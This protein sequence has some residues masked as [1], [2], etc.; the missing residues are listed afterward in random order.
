MKRRKG[1][2]PLAP[3]LSFRGRVNGT[4]FACQYRRRPRPQSKARTKPHT[5]AGRAGSAGGSA[6][7]RAGWRASCL[8]KVTM[9][10]VSLPPCL[11]LSL[12][13]HLSLVDNRARAGWRMQNSLANN[14]SAPTLQP[15]RRRRRRCVCRPGHVPQF[16]IG[17]PHGVSESVAVY[18]RIGLTNTKNIAHLAGGTRK[19][20]VLCL[21]TNLKLVSKSVT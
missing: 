13:L 1:R 9:Q 8:Q 2:S 7:R 14:F 10:R 6:G 19:N 16:V 15:R 5:C 4:R 17:F 11:P 18:L 3:P 12:S 21:A 20:L